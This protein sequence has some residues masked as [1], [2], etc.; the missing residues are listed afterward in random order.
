MKGSRRSWR[1]AN[2]SSSVSRLDTSGVMRLALRMAGM[3]KVPADS[4]VVVPEKNV[5]KALFAIDVAEA[6][7][8]LAK[9]LGFDVVIAH[10]PLGEARVRF[11]EVTR[12]H[13]EFMVEKGV[14]RK[15]A[16]ELT[17]A[18][19]DAVAVR[20][21]PANYSAIGD[22]ARISG[23]ALM[24]IHQPIDQVTRE[25][26]LGRIAA[27]EGDTVGDMVDRLASMRE[28]KNAA[29]KIEVR[30][31]SRKA[32]L[33]KWVLVF[34]AGTNGGYPM[35]KAY[36]DN[37]VDT[38][39]YLHIDQGELQRLREECD[40]NL[41]VLGHMAGDSIGAN[42]FVSALR[43]KGVRVETLGVIH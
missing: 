19:S 22:F 20:S 17:V 34:A 36:F 3:D 41:V 28:F 9:Q 18:L 6:E 16:R 35:A 33:G 43:E 39:V 31:G 38:V 15:L 8:L 4:C 24:N 30:M 26:L 37:G 2:P 40:G 42:I 10:H 14:P 7:V 11:H 25:V 27:A 5:R 23:V 21:H 13:E 1:S 32:N 29:T 12:R